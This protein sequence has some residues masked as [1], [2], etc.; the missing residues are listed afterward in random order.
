M[1]Y[2]RIGVREVK[3]R[4]GVEPS[5]VVDI[6]ALTGDTIDNIKGV[7]GVG[8]KTAAALIQKFGGIKQLYEGLDRIEESGIRGAKK[9][10]GLLAGHRAAGDLAG[11]LVRIEPHMSH[12]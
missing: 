5:A 12:N 9:V 8:E 6:Q 1:L 10:A 3:E 7:P 11:E 4:F 2:R